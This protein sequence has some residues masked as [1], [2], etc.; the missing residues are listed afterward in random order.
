MAIL[1]QR[2]A[3]PEGGG[4]S[5]ADPRGSPSTPCVIQLY[6]LLLDV[7]PQARLELT[8]PATDPKP[9]RGGQG[10]GTVPYN[11]HQLPQAS[12]AKRGRKILVLL[13]LQL[14]D[15]SSRDRP[16]PSQNRPQLRSPQLGPTRSPLG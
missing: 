11:L 7:Q 3:Y 12:P 16:P 10:E 1:E 8:P 14:Q 2:G 4:R 15:K 6:V 5:K 13:T 9:N